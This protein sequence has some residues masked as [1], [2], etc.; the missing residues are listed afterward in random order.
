MYTLKND[1][2]EITLLD[3]VADRAQLGT[4]YCTAGYIY[5]VTDARHGELMSG[6][7]YPD[8]F[9]VFDG[10]GIPDSFNLSPLLAWPG[11]KHPQQPLPEVPKDAHALVLGIGVCDLDTST[12][13]TWCDWDVEVEPTVIKMSTHHPLVDP[14]PQRRQTHP[15]PLVPAPLLPAPGDGRAD[16]AEY[17]GDLSR[18]PRLYHGTQR[19]HQPQEL[20]MAGRTLPGP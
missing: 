1:A 9:N 13:V 7:T 2:L 8:S 19:L 15:H 10:Q 4:R 18:E 3:P 17:P 14:G 12:V 20:A 6:P 11:P 5:S 16:Q